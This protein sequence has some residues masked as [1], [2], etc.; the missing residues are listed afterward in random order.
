MGAIDS[1]PGSGVLFLITYR[2][3]KQSLPF[4][5]RFSLVRYLTLI[6]ILDRLLL[7]IPYSVNVLGP[8]EL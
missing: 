7:R 4:R 5:L 6:C 8:V 2:I 3:Q 1:Y